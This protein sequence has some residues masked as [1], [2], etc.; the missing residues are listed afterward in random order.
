MAPSSPIGPR[1]AIGEPLQPR[2]RPLRVRGDD[3]G[4]WGGHR[5]RTARRSGPASW[6][7]CW[8]RRAPSASEGHAPCWSAAR[9]GSARPTW[10]APPPTNSAPTASRWRGVAPTRWSARCRT[11]RSPRSSPRCPGDTSWRRGPRRRARRRPS[12][13]RC[14]CRWP[15]SSSEACA[16]GPLV[17]VID[18]L[19]HAD[20]DTLVLLGFLVR[21]MADHPIAWVMTARPHVA[22]PSPA[23]TALLHGLREDR[24]LDEIP[25]AALDH[26]SVAHLAGATIGRPLDDAAREVVVR[27]ASG[28]PFFA[29]QLA[30]SLAEAGTLDGADGCARRARVAT[31]RAART[32]GPARRGRPRRRAGRRRVRRHRPRPARRPR[33]PP[34]RRAATGCTTAST[35]SCAPSSCGRRAI[36]SSSPTT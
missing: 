22:D 16:A 32:G 3:A 26:A 9:P 24:R 20:E 4:T 29:I 6:G 30:L 13:T 36:A 25:L 11:R 5:D 10:R 28:N 8:P 7:S 35:A 12:A 18:D 23:L 15:R 17:V 2:R 14:P 19:H 33:R 31:G 27:R 1:A 34:R 21:R